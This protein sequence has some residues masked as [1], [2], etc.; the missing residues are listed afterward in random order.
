VHTGK[1]QRGQTP[2]AIKV[3]ADASGPTRCGR[4]RELRS[5]SGQVGPPPPSRGA[6]VTGIITK[7]C[8]RDALALLYYMIMIPQLSPAVTCVVTTCNHRDTSH[9]QAGTVDSNMA[10][11]SCHGSS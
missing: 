9:C 2:G 4:A 3:D 8:S 10:F 7:S 6:T 11:R 1:A 5:L